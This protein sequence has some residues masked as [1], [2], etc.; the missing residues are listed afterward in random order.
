MIARLRHRL[1]EWYWL[2]A[3]GPERGDW[4]LNAD[5]YAQCNRCGYVDKSVRFDLP[6]RTP[7]DA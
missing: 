3:L 4:H 5:K 7:F 1:C 6:E 2:L